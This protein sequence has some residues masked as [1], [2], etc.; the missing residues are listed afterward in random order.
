[1]STFDESKVRRQ[2]E[3][4]T[5]GGQFATRPKGESSVSLAA[6]APLDSQALALAKAA[7]WRTALQAPYLDE[8]GAEDD[9]GFVPCLR[10]GASVCSSETDA[11]TYGDHREP[12]D[13]DHVD[14]ESRS[15]VETEFETWVGE[16]HQLVQSF[17]ELAE[18]QDSDIAEQLGERWWMK[19]A[20]QRGFTD[21]LDD[22]PAY[23]DAK[24]EL[25]RARH[26]IEDS[27]VGYSHGSNEAAIAA[28]ERALDEIR[29][30]TPLDILRQRAEVADSAWRSSYGASYRRLHDGRST[31]KTYSEAADRE[32]SAAEAKKKADRDVRRV[33]TLIA[34]DDATD[35]RD[36]YLFLDGNGRAALG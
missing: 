26:N 19:T 3:G 11:H 14:A 34:L 13:V 6:T 32:R 21:L 4:V 15:R 31:S 1:M 23:A 27:R 24:R 29:N 8:Y 12:L 7:L 2:P 5:T 28:H 18:Q 17:I 33:E 35:S 16:N 36:Y 9:E 30:A 22:D 10:C 25:A 20:G